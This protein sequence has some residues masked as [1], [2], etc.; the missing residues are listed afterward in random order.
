M[1][2]RSNRPRGQSSQGDAR[3]FAGMR[4]GN[5]HAAGVDSGAHA[6]MACVPVGDA[7]PLVRALGTDT[8]ALD[9]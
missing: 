9:A 2:T 5:P 1:R 6:M 4:Q 7:Q 3:P 8:A